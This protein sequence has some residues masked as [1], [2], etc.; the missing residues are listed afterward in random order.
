MENFKDFTMHEIARFLAITWTIQFSLCY[1]RCSLK[2]SVTNKKLKLY[3]P[4]NERA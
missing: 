2:V 4:L 3:W 1:I